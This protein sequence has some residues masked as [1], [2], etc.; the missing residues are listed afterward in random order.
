MLPIYELYW[1][2]W[3]ITCVVVFLIYLKENFRSF[4]IPLLTYIFGYP[5]YV[6]WN[7]QYGVQDY[8][9]TLHLK[10][11][12]LGSLIALVMPLLLRDFSKNVCLTMA[13]VSIFWPILGNHSLTACFMLCMMSVYGFNWVYVIA[14]VVHPTALGMGGLVFSYA[15]WKYGYRSLLLFIVIPFLQWVDFF[16][17]SG[18]FN[19]WAQVWKWFWHRHRIWFGYGPGS[20]TQ[21]GPQIATP[22]EAEDF[23][24]LY[25]IFTHNEP[26]QFLFEYGIVG[27]ILSLPVIWYLRKEK[28]FPVFCFVSFFNYPFRN[29]LFSVFV[30]WIILNSL[31]KHRVISSDSLTGPLS[32]A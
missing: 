25:F 23:Y 16:S 7:Q 13:C 29:G 1:L 11:M 2:P 17:N 27:I 6:A 20:F 18:R 30:C 14:I 21:Y 26:L 12:A 3:L 31:R 4:S 32:R 19:L 28:W 22:I 24:T 5:I 15:W 8:A 10:Y 9:F